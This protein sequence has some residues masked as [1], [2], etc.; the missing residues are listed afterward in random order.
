MMRRQSEVFLLGARHMWIYLYLQTS[1][2]FGNDT[3]IFRL[4]RWLIDNQHDLLFG[5]GPT[6][7]LGAD[8]VMM[9][10]NKVVSMMLRRG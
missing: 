5:H 2:G 3:E 4:E 9:K 6:R 8:I 7:C 1:P 10:I